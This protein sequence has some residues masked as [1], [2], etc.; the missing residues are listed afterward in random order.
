MANTFEAAPARNAPGGTSSQVDAVVVG[1]GF[2]GLYLAYR[3]SRMGMTV[4]V[5]EAG[6]DVGG[7]WY[8]N[9]YPGARCDIESLDYAFTFERELLSEW[10]WTERYAKQADILA[11][12]N[13]VADRF[14]LRRFITLDTRVTSLTY[15]EPGAA[16]QVGTAGGIAATAAY[17]VMA[18]GCLS[19]A[20]VPKIPGLENFAGTTYHTGSWPHGGVDFSGR[21]VAVIGTGSSGVQSI[22][23]IAESAEHLTVLQRTPNFVTPAWN[24]E[25]AAQLSDDI[26]ANYPARR[27]ANRASFFGVDLPAN[28]RNA[29]D[30]TP[31]ECEATLERYWETGGLTMLGSFA[32]VII[33][34]ESNKIV[35]DFIRAKIRKAVK[36]PTV[37]ELLSPKNHTFGTKRPCV[38]TNYYETYN[39][40]NVE[41]VDLNATPIEAITT[42]G[43]RTSSR[44]YDVDAIVFATGFDAM[45]GALLA[46]DIRGAG[47]ASLRDKWADGPRT[48]L[49]IA[50]AGFPNL[51]M[52]TGPGSPSVLSNMV[53]SIEQHVDWITDA[54][55][56]AH[57]AGIAT[58]EASKEAEDAWVAHV[59]EVAHYTLY[60]HTDSWYTGANIPGKPRVFMPYIGG[61]GAY[62]AHC[63][64]VAAKNYEGFLLSTSATVA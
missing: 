54:I 41:L 36:D 40:A 32:D 33:N 38:G 5:F 12:L 1:A 2:S 56:H 6:G 43:I 57:R 63:A 26:R 3:L 53:T 16:W 37:A 48:Y 31:E 29:V 44:E 62:R 11:Y 13:H 61:V 58:F 49:G 17:V 8:W 18:T 46:V 22:P 45:T 21:R 27:D 15:D 64:N 9:R 55:D 50:T 60:P 7:T 52:V 25:L 51:F 39:R 10:T 42:A 47:G 59:D 28:P 24:G 23:I 19:A 35:A 20:R 30:C 4:R 34:P 14:D